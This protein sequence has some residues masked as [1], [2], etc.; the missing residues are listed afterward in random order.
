MIYVSLNGSIRVVELETGKLVREYN[1]VYKGINNVLDICVLPS[2]DDHFFILL[3][4]ANGGQ[5]W[6]V[7][8]SA[9]DVWMDTEWPVTRGFSD[10]SFVDWSTRTFYYHINGTDTWTTVELPEKLVQYAKLKQ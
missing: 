3:D 5:P 2:K 10:S 9:T 1:A 8:S 7:F 6:R 4:C